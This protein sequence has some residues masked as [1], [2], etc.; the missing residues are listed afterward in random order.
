M[1]SQDLFYDGFDVID[2]GF[3]YKLSVKEIWSRNKLK[4]TIFWSGF[5]NKSSLLWKKITYK[6]TLSI[7]KKSHPKNYRIN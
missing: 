5:Y 1:Q 2:V 3:F 7:P 4:H 6:I